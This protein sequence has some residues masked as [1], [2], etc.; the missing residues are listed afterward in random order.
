MLPANNMWRIRLEQTTKKN[1]FF[2]PVL[3]DGTQSELRGKQ[4]KA[5]ITEATLH[6][7]RD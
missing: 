7:I 5:G 2:V 1:D 6:T 4:S 3:T